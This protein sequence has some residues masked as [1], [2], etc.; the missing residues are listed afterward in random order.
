MHSRNS[1]HS[2]GLPEPGWTRLSADKRAAILRAFDQLSITDQQAVLSVVCACQAK[3]YADPD[4]VRAW[5]ERMKDPTA[6][7]SNKH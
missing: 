7:I 4:L 5:T 6:T 2:P 3:T 1:P